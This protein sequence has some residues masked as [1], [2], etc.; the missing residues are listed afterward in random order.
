MKKRILLVAVV[1]ILSATL[2][3]A[4]V[5]AKLTAIEVLRELYKDIG[6]AQSITQEISVKKG[7]FT[8][9]ES[10]KTYAKAESGYDVT[11]S[12][13]RLND[14]DAEQLYE[15]T[16]INSHIDGAEEAAP[17]VNLDESFFEEGYRLTESGLT[18]MV[19][20]D[21]ITD[22]FGVTSEQ[23]TAPTSNLMLELTVSGGH[24]SGVRITYESNGAD[25][26]ITLTM[27][28]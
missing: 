12:E 20:A 17:T 1:L 26:T 3:A 11:G 19:K 14:A 18:A 28:Y 8:Q 25:V 22:V 23:L 10:S 27:T 16:E 13:K 4:C 21:H 5:E 24:M 15:V 9:F 6:T 7:N 2:F